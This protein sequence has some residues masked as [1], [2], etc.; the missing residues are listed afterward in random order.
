MT[1]QNIEYYWDSC[2]II[3]ELR[4]SSISWVTRDLSEIIWSFSWEQVSIKMKNQDIRLNSWSIENVK[5]PIDSELPVH[6]DRE[7]WC[8]MA[9]FRRNTMRIKIFKGPGDCLNNTGG[10]IQ[11]T[12]YTGSFTYYIIRET[13]PT[14]NCQM[15]S[16]MAPSRE[17]KRVGW[18]YSCMEGLWRCRLIPLQKPRNKSITNTEAIK[19]CLINGD[20]DALKSV[21]NL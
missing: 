14:A 9:C 10:H 17:E 13:E 20:K 5:Q 15:L 4:V 2:K 12:T 6:R 11:K 21:E 8:D 1:E 3:V 16:V 19:R 18:L 7:R